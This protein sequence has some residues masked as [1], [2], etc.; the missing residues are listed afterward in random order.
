MQA[1]VQEW[2]NLDVHQVSNILLVPFAHLGLQVTCTSNKKNKTIAERIVKGRH[3]KTG[4]CC[5]GDQYIYVCATD[6][7]CE[8]LGRFNMVKDSKAPNYI[9]MRALYSSLPMPIYN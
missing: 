3:P 9:A 5:G 4:K 8:A 2:N 1:A 6:P 7:E